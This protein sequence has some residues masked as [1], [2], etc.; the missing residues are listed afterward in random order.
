M[1]S[2]CTVVALPPPAPL[3]PFL[4]VLIFASSCIVIA[5]ASICMS[6][7]VSV[8][9]LS[10]CNRCATSAI[11]AAVLFSLGGAYLLI[12]FVTEVSPSCSFARTSSSRAFLPSASLPNTRIPRVSTGRVPGTTGRRLPG[13]WL[14]YVSLSAVSP[15]AAFA[16]LPA[17][18]LHKSYRSAASFALRSLLRSLWS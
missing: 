2:I 13:L 12:S 15:A 16:A 18:V 5:R 10:L 1:A 9:S 17:G 3:P 8:A 6:A 4:A 11:Y 14:R 7:S